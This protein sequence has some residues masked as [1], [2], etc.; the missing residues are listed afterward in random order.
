[1]NNRNTASVHIQD[2][3]ENIESSFGDTLLLKKWWIRGHID[4]LAVLKQ[5]KDK[6]EHFLSLILRKNPIKY[7]IGMKVRMF[8]VD[9]EGNK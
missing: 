6:V 9:K 3:G 7:Y 2:D 1:M 8:K 5:Y 4:P